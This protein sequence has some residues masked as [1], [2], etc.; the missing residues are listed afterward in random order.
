MWDLIVYLA[1]GEPGRHE[2][3]AFETVASYQTYEACDA[4]RWRWFREERMPPGYSPRF[5][6]DG[7]KGWLYN[8]VPDCERRALVG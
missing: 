5:V 3:Q 7:R 1:F 4:A 8:S 2:R 6:V